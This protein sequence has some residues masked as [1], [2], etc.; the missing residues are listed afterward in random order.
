MQIQIHTDNHVE[1]YKRMEDYYSTAIEE[2]LKRFSEKITSLHI[3]LG[4][5][6]SEKF[7]TDDKRCTIEARIAGLKP[8]AVVNHAD[9]VE[10]AVNGATAKLKHLLETTFDKM[11]TH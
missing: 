9:T 5:E 8:V 11:K 2:S 1:G 4:D 6:N 10:K 3:H 7:S